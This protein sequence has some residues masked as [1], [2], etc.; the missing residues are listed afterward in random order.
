MDRKHHRNTF[1]KG[2]IKIDPLLKRCLIRDAQERGQTVLNFIILSDGPGGAISIPKTTYIMHPPTRIWLPMLFHYNIPLTP[3]KLRFIS[4]EEEAYIY[5]VI[6]PGIPGHWEDFSYREM[7]K[8]DVLF[9][10]DNIKRNTLGVY[11]MAFDKE[12]LKTN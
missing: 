7:R 5:T 2:Q 11:N 4:E 12:D 10:I 8:G 6:F 1:Q 3:N 9:G